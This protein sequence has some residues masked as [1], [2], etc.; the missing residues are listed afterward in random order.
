MDIVYYPHPALLEPTKAVEPDQAEGLGEKIREMFDLMY[1]YRG[2]G[3]A[4]P[5]VAWNVRLFIVN[6]TGEA[7]DERVLINPRIIGS[8]GNEEGE[9]GCLSFPG[10]YAKVRRALNI[11]VEYQD[12]RF[13]SH[14]LDC[15]GLLAR[16]I[17][18]ELDHLDNILLVHRMTEADKFINRKKLKELKERISTP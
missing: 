4:A 12:E 13:E 9:E 1:R 3:L 8:D 2:V 10:I 6:P 5:Q 15:S 17:Q 16:I 18:H 7:E 14:K 11:T